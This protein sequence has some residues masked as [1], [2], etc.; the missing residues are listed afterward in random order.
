MTYT[1]ISTPSAQEQLLPAVSTKR[2]LEPGVR[3]IS[4]FTVA[5][6]SP[7]RRRAGDI[8]LHLRLQHTLP[9]LAFRT[10]C[11]SLTTASVIP[12]L[13]QTPARRIPASARG[14]GPA[15]A[16]GNR[17]SALA[18]DVGCD[19]IAPWR[20]ADAQP[21]PGRPGKLFRTPR[22]R[23][24]GEKQWMASL[25]PGM[26]RSPGRSSGAEACWLAERGP[27]NRAVATCA[28]DGLRASLWP[29]PRPCLS[30]GAPPSSPL[31]CAAPPHPWPSS[32]F[33]SYHHRS[34][35]SGVRKGQISKPLR[36]FW[37]D[38]QLVSIWKIP[39][40]Q[41]SLRKWT[42][43]SPDPDCAHL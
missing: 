18:R 20:Q 24:L 32:S 38:L 33:C 29:P 35:G 11:L 16:L 41:K 23:S 8:S 2:A 14:V 6:V 21:S 13:P 9:R 7:T 39:P 15:R 3:P 34:R 43:A 12:A 28:E 4:A 19:V 30:P 17:A 25:S 40:L 42:P 27:E 5:S 36:T 1:G 37:L 10:P 31:D 22:N 26:T